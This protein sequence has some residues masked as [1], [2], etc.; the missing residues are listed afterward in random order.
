ME[1]ENEK[2]SM[3]ES[4]LDS[5]LKVF[6]VLGLQYF[7]LKHLTRENV[8]KGPSFCRV[9]V[10]LVLLIFVC[11]L[12]IFFI[13]ESES[14]ERVT[15]KNVVIFAVKNSLNFGLLAV[16]SISI[17]ESFVCTKNVK[18]VFLNLKTLVETS[19]QKLG[20]SVNLKSFKKSVWKRMLSTFLV[21]S[22][23]HVSIAVVYMNNID[24]F[25]NIVLVSVPLIFFMIVVV[26]INFYV[27]LINFELEILN[28]MVAETFHQQ[29]FKIIENIN[30]HLTSVK[31]CIDPLEDLRVT[32]EV[33]NLIYESGKLINES[34]GLTVLTML[35]SSVVSLTVS[36]YELFIVCIG[37]MSANIV[38][39]ET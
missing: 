25:I 26:K 38:P 11:T 33:F 21:L 35:T 37:G 18:K 8:N 16:C 23:A 9:A 7:S 34:I 13:V 32:R 31:S 24:D 20:V 3:M 6:E 19:H 12:L 22:V 1:K 10:M 39:G 2:N 36:S 17:I 14:L 30:V 29:P 27:H 15:A 28:Q 5:C 4:D